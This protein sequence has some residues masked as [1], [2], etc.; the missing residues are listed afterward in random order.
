MWSTWTIRQRFC[1]FLMITSSSVCTYLF[2][3]CLFILRTIIRFILFNL[4]S[5][6]YFLNWVSLFSLALQFCFGTFSLLQYRP[7]YIKNLRRQIS[8]LYSMSHSRV[9]F[10]L[11]KNK[12]N[13]S[14]MSMIFPFFT[15][16]I[17]L[18]HIIWSYDVIHD[19]I[20]IKKT[21]I[22]IIIIII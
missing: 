1:N 7:L 13:P 20:V 21:G 15:F 11:L 14:F 16:Q 9:K 10:E 17:L 5:Y 2:G 19:M 18:G 22:I 4:I 3:Y 8:I 6:I 12:K